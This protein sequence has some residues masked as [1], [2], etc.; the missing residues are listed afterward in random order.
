MHNGVRRISSSLKYWVPVILWMC[1]IFSASTD[2][3]SS[4]H[5]SR[6]IGPVVR[7]LIPDI[8]DRAVG[9][10]VFTVRKAAHVTEYAILAVLFWWAR[11]NSIAVVG[12][13]SER[14]WR[15]SE[16][17]LALVVV[18]LYATT[19][20]IHQLFVPTREG[21]IGDVM[22]DS[23]GAALGLLGIWVAGRWRRRW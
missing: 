4:G 14:R 16:A 1:V 7:W 2:A 18:A 21:R 11:R 19:D 22:L 15:W 10:I 6:I 17:L 3:M 8:S 9:Q 12:G 5:T 13:V 23:A 20:E